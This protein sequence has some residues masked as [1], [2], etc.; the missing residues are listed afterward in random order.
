MK[1]FYLIGLLIVLALSLSVVSASDDVS[2]SNGT[3]GVDE[4]LSSQNQEINILSDE[5]DDS[6]VQSIG[7][8]CG[9]D[10]NNN[11]SDSEINDADDVCK[12]DD[13]NCN[14]S[15]V[16]IEADNLKA[17]FG[18]DKYK[19]R[20]LNSSGDGI[21]YVNVTL[22]YKGEDHIVT[23]K[24]SGI[25]THVLGLNVGKW[26]ITI[27]CQNH[28][29]M[30]NVTILPKP[31][32]KISK[33]KASNVYTTYGKKI[34]YKVAVLDKAGKGIKNKLVIIKIGK[35]RYVTKTNQLGVASFTFNYPSGKYVIKYYVDKFKGSKLYVVSNKVT[36]TI[37]KWGLKGDVTKNKLIKSYVPKN[38][39]VKKAVEA[40]KKGIPLLKFEGGKGKTVFI[41]SGVHGNEISSQVAAMK[42]IA[43]LTKV[44]IKGTVYFIPFVNVKAISKSVRYTDRDFNRIANKYGPIPNKIVNIIVKCKCD[45][46]GDFHTTKPGGAPGQNIVMGFKS[47]A[48][49]CA[50]M[51]NYI[52]KNCNVNK[53]LYS[54]AGQV[55]PGALADNVNKHGIPGVICEVVLP[56]NTVTAKSVGISFSMMKHLLKFNSI[57]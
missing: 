20:L 15:D 25:A 18:N 11:D 55:Y 28:S 40:T 2:V 51:T 17:Y 27:S 35:K 46:Y 14:N 31:V 19:F 12:T 36:F 29:V 43:S 10:L 21:A 33:I 23:T 3:L 4:V 13:G 16:V 5:S 52:Y 57:L 37:L 24:G 26:N 30:R 42:M 34:K 9:T 45:A 6:N 41:T 8:V 48:K 44:P 38:V 1:K 53:R 56:H 39:W 49:T 32:P 54:Y 7:D 47:P 50:K 22:T